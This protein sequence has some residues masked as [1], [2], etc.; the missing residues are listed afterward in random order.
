MA[1]YEQ[2]Y[3]VFTEEMNTLGLHYHEELY[4]AVTKH[5]GPSIHSRDASLVACSDPNELKTIKESFLMGRLAMED[6]PRLDE[7]IK[8]VCGALGESNRN[9]HRATFYY[10]LVAILQKEHEFIDTAK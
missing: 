1:T 4:H 9:K 10:L 7:V 3:K 6:S 2:A 8:E 5:L